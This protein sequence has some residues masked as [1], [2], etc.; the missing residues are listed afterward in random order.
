MVIR[1]N[2]REKLSLV[3]LCFVAMVISYI[4]RVSFSSAIAPLSEE[5]GWSPLTRGWLLASFFFGYV[6]GQIPASWIVNRFGGRL[7]MAIAL[8][9]WSAATA[10]TPLAAQTNGLALLITIR[11]VMGLGEAAVTPCIY[12]LVAQCV[13]KHQ[14][15]RT[16]A[17]IIGGV[18][19]GTIAALLIAS[20]VLA[21]YDWAW[22]F[23]ASGAGGLLFAALWMKV[24]RPKVTPKTHLD[25][26]INPEFA[27]D[28]SYVTNINIVP[29]RE[30]LRSPAVLALI[31]NHFCSNWTAYVL[32][33]WLPT[34]F[35]AFKDLG[36]ESVGLMSAIPWLCLFVSANLAAIFAD[37]LIH[38]G[39]GVTVVRKMMQVI[40][41]IGSAIFLCVAANQST[42][43]A[44]LVSLS[45]ALAILGFTWSGFLPNHLD[46]APKY[47][48]VLSGISNTAGSLPGVFG[49]VVTGWIFE[50]TGQFTTAL[51]L[52]AVVNVVGAII[53][54]VWGTGEKVIH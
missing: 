28:I 46:I 23:Y 6:L 32:I 48:D 36:I 14:Q 20:W 16:M 34:Y 11:V 42:P 41:L 25:N 10:L 43:F 40:G 2:S 12:N 51:V 31:C 53:W 24:I 33:A 22:L 30:I 5:F 54:L 44:A 37:W 35:L 1:V 3:V 52:A 7:V 9:L 21:N 38:R 15:S 13:P 39:V 50:V 26:E 19:V 8:I 18:P 49:V 4:D 17:F 27:E 29:W 45:I 47:A